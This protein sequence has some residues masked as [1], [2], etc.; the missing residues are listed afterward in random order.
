[1]RSWL[2]SEDWLPVWL[3]A[4]LVLIAVPTAAGV[5]LL[6]WVAAPRVWLSP[7]EAVR[8]VSAGYAALPAF[9][10][11]ILTYLLVLVLVGLWAAAR[12]IELRAFVPGFTVI[13]WASALGSLLGNYAYIAQTPDKRSAMGIGW[14]LGL[15]GRGGLPRRAAGGP[16]R[17]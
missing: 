6:G 5:D 9:A 16:V 7:A 12:K 14:S 4:A 1:M 10:N 15:D 11:L 17:R 8:P 3:G 13:F 2:T